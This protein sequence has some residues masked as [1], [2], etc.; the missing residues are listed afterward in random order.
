MKKWSWKK[1]SAIGVSAMLAFSLTFGLVFSDLSPN[2]GPDS[3]ENGITDSIEGGGTNSSVNN[4]AASNNT[5]IADAASGLSTYSAGDTFWYTDFATGVAMGD[6]YAANGVNKEGATDR[7]VKTVLDPATNKGTINNP[8]V[9]T[10]TVAGW[11]AFVTYVSKDANKGL[12]KVFVLNGDIDFG[13]ATINS[14]EV[15]RGW[16]LGNGYTFSNIKYKVYTNQPLGLFCSVYGD[17]VFFSDL[18]IKNY[19]MSGG[20]GQGGGLVG[21]SEANLTVTGVTTTGTATIANPTNTNLASICPG[22][23]YTNYGGIVGMAHGANRTINVYKCSTNITMTI[24]NNEGT[25]VG[26]GGIIGCGEGAGNP[27][28]TESKA[29]AAI[30]AI[31]IYDC[32]SAAKTTYSTTSSTSCQLWTGLLAFTRVVKKTTIKRCMTVYDLTVTGASDYIGAG[33]LLTEA[34]NYPTID[35]T[36]DNYVVEDIY[37]YGNFTFNGTKYAMPLAAKHSGETASSISVKNCKVYSDNKNYFVPSTNGTRPVYP[38]NPQWTAVNN[39]PAA[40]LDEFKQAASDKLNNPAVWSTD[41]ID[42]IETTTKTPDITETPVVVSKTRITF[43]ETD[44][45][46]MSLVGGANPVEYEMSDGDV[47]NLPEP[48]NKTPDGKSFVGWSLSKTSYD[49]PLTKFPK[50]LYGN[51][52]MYPVWDMTG[53]TV[54]ANAVAAELTDG[55]VDTTNRTATA[56][57]IDGKAVI[58]LSAQV[59]P[60]AGLSSSDYEI[61]WSWYKGTTP[62]SGATTDTLVLTDMT[63]GVY[64]AHA[65]LKHKTQL[66]RTKS[67][68]VSLGW[69]VKIEQGALT[70]G[71]ITLADKDAENNDIFAYWGQRLSDLTDYVVPTMTNTAGDPISGT[72]RW[73]RDAQTVEKYQTDYEATFVPDASY[74]G[75]YPETPIKVTIN[76]TVLQLVFRFSVPTLTVED[77]TFTFDMPYAYADSDPDVAKPEYTRAEVAQLFEDQ[78]FELLDAYQA[79]S[80]PLE[81][82]IYNVLVGRM[83]SFPVQIAANASPDA[84]TLPITT[85]RGENGAEK[86]LFFNADGVARPNYIVKTKSKDGT[87]AVLTVP[88]TIAADKTTPFTVTLNRTIVSNMR[89]DETKQV[90]YGALI[91]DPKLSIYTAAGKTYFHAGWYKVDRVF[92]LE[93]ELPMKGTGAEAMVDAPVW[94]FSGNRVNGDTV[95]AADWRSGYVKLKSITAETKIAE[96]TAR[97]TPKASDYIVTG[98]YSVSETAGGAEIGEVKLILSTDDYTVKGTGGDILYHVG[99][100]D[101]SGKNFTVKVT[102]NQTA[103]NGQAIDYDLKVKV[104]KKY[105]DLSGLYFPAKEIQVDPNKPQEYERVELADYLEKQQV[106]PTDYN[107]QDVTYEYSTPSGK[108]VEVSEL[109]KAGTYYVKLTIHWL[110]DDLISDSVSTTWTL[111]EQPREV[112]VEWDREDNFEFTYNGQHQQP[113]ARFYL[114]QDDPTAE[115]KYLTFAFEYTGKGGNAEVAVG[116]NEYTIGVVPRNSRYVLADEAKAEMKFKIIKAQIKLPEFEANASFEYQP[117]GYNLA[118]QLGYTDDELEHLVVVTGAV[119]EKVSSAYTLTVKLKDDRNSEWVGGGTK[120]Q[121]YPWSI[122]KKALMFPTFTETLTYNG[123]KYYI[124]DYVNYFDPELMEFDHS[125]EYSESGYGDYKVLVTLKDETNYMWENEPAD[126]KLSWRI[127]K[128]KL[129]LTWTGWKFLY[130]ASAMN[131]YAP[132]VKALNGLVSEDDEKHFADKIAENLSYSGDLERREAGSYK[133]EVSIKPG[134]DLDKNYELAAS[135]KIFYWVVKGSEQEV[136]IKIEWNLPSDGRYTFNGTIQSPTVSA[137]YGEDNM[138]LAVGDYQISYEGNTDSQWAGQYSVTA[139]I[140]TYD[141]TPLRLVGDSVTYIIRANGTEGQKPVEP[142]KD[143]DGEGDTPSGGTIGAIPQL[144][145]S[146]VALVFILVFT[147][148][149]LNYASVAKNARRKVKKLAQMTYSFS[150]V[151]LLTLGLFGLSETNWWIIAGALMGVALF[152]AIIMFVF[153]GKSKK[154]LLMLEEEQDRIEE[155]KE[156]AREAERER[157]DNEFKMMFAA[158]QQNYQQPQVGYDDMQNMIAS[159][160]TALLPGLQQT[161]QALPPAQSEND[162]LR[163]QMAQQQEMINQ[164]MQERNA[165]YAAPAM[166]NYNDVEQ[167]VAAVFGDDGD[168]VSLEELYGQMS[169]DAKRLY[170][171]IGGYIMSKPDTMQNDGKYAVL[172]K[173]CGKTLFKL[174]IKNDM[175]ILYYAID[176]GSKGEV[177][178]SD[179]AALEV[180]KGIVDLR[181]S[182]SGR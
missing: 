168:L 121:S 32:Y 118:T 39:S 136:I 64:T 30:A 96:F 43:T 119:G 28:A 103:D 112:L 34:Q 3:A 5:L 100:E 172:F 101:G 145:I 1:I 149:T 106:L 135:E 48:V 85:Y 155:E 9:I 27:V 120:T 46:P 95:I 24:T 165:G 47:T 33:L 122:T 6:Y 71:A 78:Y 158:M 141:G 140:T 77:K 111:T 14:V 20:N 98:I 21:H 81:K 116:V 12:N 130:S 125:G 164:L 117:G 171:E 50:N 4:Y 17:S 18:T 49:N 176:N 26:A 105:I 80:D 25:W 166:P 160:V 10:N 60:P 8:Y 97:S 169:D 159:A 152:M 16:F 90:G 181:I 143:P 94:S 42:K 38:S 59:T 75:N 124:E 91:A 56:K 147:I 131:P 154:A 162:D 88:V 13:N 107:E 54:T 148:M 41:S 93:E 115:K 129:Y 153:R 138:P 87:S 142:D 151:G 58:T 110:D 36:A 114:K 175:P 170:Y 127:Q 40:S 84:A 68:A 11:N 128:K 102:A 133:I 63:D 163:A 19:T 92:G 126:C 137:L 123:Q 89:T 108:K 74:Q 31:N 57:Y 99:T 180:A 55:E 22:S 70:Q 109:I 7:I 53:V 146:G 144:I 173:Y 76:P 44:G 157:R 73:S 132:R 52:T 161:M 139:V 29:T 65:A 178:I 51:V 62:V 113:E 86:V 179:P 134:S 83:P 82:D 61:V 67:D 182:Q 15:F 174:C 66:W 37:G 79:S 23:S 2:G 150:P 69:T 45:T 156:M 177:P 104:V 72:I 35:S 167:E